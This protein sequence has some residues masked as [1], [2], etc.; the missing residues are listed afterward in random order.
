MS[1][2]SK[3]EKAKKI[4]VLS[5]E[6]QM[7]FDYTVEEI[8]SLGRYPHQKGF[9]KMLSAYDRQVIDAVMEIT[10]VERFRK[11]QFRLIEWWRKT[12]CLIGKSIGARAGNFIVR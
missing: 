3:L 7:T 4:A 2:L 10:K 5:Q 11:T 12:T 1:K 6:V 9:L 8:I